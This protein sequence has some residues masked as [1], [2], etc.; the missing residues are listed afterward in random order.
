MP[1]DDLCNKIKAF[2]LF[3]SYYLKKLFTYYK[4]YIYETAFSLLS[5]RRTG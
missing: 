4:I 2:F 1:I 5:G 3:L